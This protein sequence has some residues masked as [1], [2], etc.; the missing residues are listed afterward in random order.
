MNGDLDV[1]GGTIT[2]TQGS[3]N[4]RQRAETGHVKTGF[5]LFFVDSVI[6]GYGGDVRVKD[7][8]PSE[9][10]FVIELPAAA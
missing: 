7:N 5:G 6:D 10:A 3:K 1:W 9:A 4:F 2:V 8:E